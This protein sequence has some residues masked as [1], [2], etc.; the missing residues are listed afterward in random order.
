MRRARKEFEEGGDGH[1][2]EMAHTSDD[3]NYEQEDDQPGTE[4]RHVSSAFSQGRRG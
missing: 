4:V 1:P 3:C 2:D